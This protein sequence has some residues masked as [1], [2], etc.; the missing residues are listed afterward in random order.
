VTTIVVT[1]MAVLRPDSVER[2]ERLHREMSAEQRAVMSRAGY[3]EMTIHR[4]AELLFLRAVRDPDGAAPAPG[5]A[6]LSARWHAETSPCFAVTWRA[7]D[8]IF[9][10]SET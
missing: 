8:S 1:Q 4:A 9:D 10:F 6:E 5:D 3:I 2:Y 7:A